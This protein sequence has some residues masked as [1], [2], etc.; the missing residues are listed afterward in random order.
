LSFS[1]KL[2]TQIS[3]FISSSESDRILKIPR[4]KGSNAF[5]PETPQGLFF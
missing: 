1:P 5:L 2:M 4:P 3:N